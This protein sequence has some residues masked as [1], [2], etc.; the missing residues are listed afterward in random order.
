V[1]SLSESNGTHKRALIDRKAMPRVYLDYCSEAEN[2]VGLSCTIIVNVMPIGCLTSVVILAEHFL[3]V[4]I[5]TERSDEGSRDLS[6]ALEMT[7]GVFDVTKVTFK[8]TIKW[9]S[10]RIVIP[11][12]RSDEGSLSLIHRSQRPIP[13]E[14]PIAPVAHYP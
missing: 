9:Q 5:P 13:N 3:P 10:L 7:E 6:H 1:L 2:A 8:K 12:E 11:T 14:L 4:V